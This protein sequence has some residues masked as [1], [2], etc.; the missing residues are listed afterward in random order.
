MAV[1]LAF[2]HIPPTCKHILGPEIVACAY[3]LLIALENIKAFPDMCLLP[4]SQ[5]ELCVINN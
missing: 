2:T 1:D 3:F 5:I 4:R